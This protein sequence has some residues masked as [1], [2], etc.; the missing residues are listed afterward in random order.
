MSFT[1]DGVRRFS[2][3]LEYYKE[4]LN[5]M[6]SNPEKILDEYSAFVSDKRNLMI[7]SDAIVR[8]GEEILFK[9]EM[10]FTSPSI[11]SMKYLFRENGE[12]IMSV[13]IYVSR[14]PREPDKFIVE[15]RGVIY[16]ELYGRGLE[17]LK[18]LLNIV[19]RRIEDL[20][21]GN[22][23]HIDKVSLLENS[24]EDRVKKI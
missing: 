14:G 22:S 9:G 7:Y 8:D 10:I 19:S 15:I 20:M 4:F 1:G 2:I 12:N 16:R 18:K 24:S 17:R 5:I 11:S 3:D 13:S 6:R 23:Q 21:L